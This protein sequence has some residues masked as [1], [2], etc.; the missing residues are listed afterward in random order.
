MYRRKQWYERKRPQ[1]VADLCQCR[2]KCKQCAIPLKH[3]GRG[4]FETNGCE[5]WIHR[6]DKCGACTLVR[7]A[8]NAPP[9]GVSCMPVF[10]SPYSR[11]WPE[12]EWR[13]DEDD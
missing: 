8:D 9:P 10:C 4:T 6:C 5:A 2:R 3:V 7:D 13:D 12:P 11:L 1:P